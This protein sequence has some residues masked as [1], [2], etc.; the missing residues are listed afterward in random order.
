M[1]DWSPLGVASS[2]E[3]GAPG[4]SPPSFP[5]DLVRGAARQDLGAEY[6][7][8]AWD[9]ARLAGARPEEELRALLL[10]ALATLASQRE[11]STRVPLGQAGYLERL[12]EDLGATARDRELVATLL[13][14]ASSGEDPGLSS[15]VGLAGD[16]RPLLL[17]GE[18]LQ[19]QRMHELEQRVADHLIAR[20]THG[21][22]HDPEAIRQAL[23][24]VEAHPIGVDGVSIRLSDEQ[25]QAVFEALCGGLT[26][27]TGG[28]GTGKTSIVVALLRVLGRLGDPPLEAVALAA[29]TGKAADRMRLA[30]HG[31]LGRIHEPAEGDLRL[32]ETRPEALTLHRLLGYS[33]TTDRFRHH[34]NNPLSHRVVVVDESSMLDLF[35]M[36]RLLRAT[37]LDAWLILL[38][39]ADQLPSVEAGAVFRDLCSSAATAERTVTLTRNYRIDVS[40][41]AGRHLLSAAT[42]VRDGKDRH[43]SGGDAEDAAIRLR[44]AAGEVRFE[45]AEMLCPGDPPQ[46]EAL[47]ERWDNERIQSLKG[48]AARIG[49]AY[50][51]G[52]EGFDEAAVRELTALFRHHDALRIL[53]VTRVE[54]GGSGTEAVNRWFHSRRLRDNPRRRSTTPF[55]AGEPVLVTQNDYPRQLY[56]GDQGLVLEVAVEGRRRAHPMAVFPRGDGFVPFPMEALRGRLELAWAIT[57]HKAQGSEYDHVT[58]ILPDQDIRLMTRELLYTAVTRARK[59]V[60]IVGDRELFLTGVARRVER[61]SGIAAALEGYTADS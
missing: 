33:P 21:N 57:V 28:P 6:V 26:V 16:Y 36:D 58:L 56:N 15:I 8:L 25:R 4:R 30:V 41:P 23:D 44:N 12:L 39:D 51:F 45:G 14:K 17:V 32:A 20:L 9:L 49:Q 46:R 60:T 18:H 5:E 42:L 38:G 52:A 34:E 59:S 29:P 19:A 22:V 35:L 3:R 27:V 40:D 53:C 43:L 1:V 61:Y 11:G 48:Y 13:E 55:H 37:R 31:A 47:L 50:R 24:D 2:L 54:A 10:L 7:F